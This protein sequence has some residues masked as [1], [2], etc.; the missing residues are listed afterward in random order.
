MDR[1]EPPLEPE[2]RRQINLTPGEARRVVT[3]SPWFIWGM[4]VF[5]T[6]F[7]IVQ[8]FVT[9]GDW[10]SALRFSAPGLFIGVVLGIRFKDWQ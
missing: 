10:L 1:L 4:V 5:W 8:L 7:I 2:P 6:G 3:Y 9:G